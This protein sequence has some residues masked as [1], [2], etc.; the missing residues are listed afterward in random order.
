[1]K[2]AIAAICL[3]CS[4]LFASCGSRDPGLAPPPELPELWC[5][6]HTELRNPAGLQAAEAMIDRAGAA[7][8]NGIAFWDVAFTYLASPQWPDPQ[9]RFLRQAMDYAIGKGMKVLALSP[10]FG[11]SND[12]LTS[13]PNMA[14]GMRVLGSRFEVDRSGRRLVFHDTFPG[15]RNP[16]FES[17]RTDWFRTGDRGVD[18]DHGVGHGSG[19]SGVVNNAPGNG[20]F[21]QLLNV[22]PW[23]QYHIRL[24]L[25]SRNYAGSPPVVEV[26]DG[27]NRRRL[28]AYS[29]IGISATQDWTQVD[30]TFNSQSASGVWLYFG[31]WGGNSGTLWFDDVSVEETALVYLIRRDGA[32][33]KV[34]D[35]LTG[36]IYRESVDY[37]PVLDPRLTASPHDLFH[38]PPVVSL[39]PSTSLKPGQAVAIDY[40]SAQPVDAD[41]LGLCLTDP[42]VNDWLADNARRVM[43]ATP[44]EADIF[45]Q[46]DEMR[47]MNSCALCRAKGMTAGGLLAWHVGQSMRLYRS[48]RPG[49]VFY[50]WNDM[51]DPFANAHSDYYLVEGD[52]AGSWRGLPSDVRI[53]NWNQDRLRQSLDWFSGRNRNQPTPHRQIVAGYYDNHNGARAAEDELRQAEGI[54]GIDGLMY[55]SWASDYSQLQSFADSA[56]NHWK[57]YRTSVLFPHWWQRFRS[58][59]D[60]SAAYL[61]KVSRTERP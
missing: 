12:A 20:R 16:G 40:Y 10:P 7:G 52:I 43:A 58:H 60:R 47:Q 25:R 36:T 50:V 46:Y 39:P 2:V 37:D 30:V 59:P 18:V 26:L 41:R 55:T 49:A 8:Y 33:L 13:N 51:F 6:L 4:I 31:V 35:P 22:V 44:P 19:T 15:V 54:P 42:A 27:G 53:M 23:R 1:M 29:Q 48:L 24:F 45:L 17:G 28:L 3:L 14:E 9:G 34:Y 21:S 61:A 11:Y 57:D 32:P 38:E 56:R 5:W